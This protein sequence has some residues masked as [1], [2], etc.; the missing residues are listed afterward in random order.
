MTFTRWF[1]LAL[2]LLTC[3][4]ASAL[5]LHSSEGDVVFNHDEHKMYVQCQV[6]HHAKKEG[7][8]AC[9]PKSN[10]FN[11]AKIFHL[12]CR[13]CHKQKKAG[14]TACNQCHQPCMHLDSRLGE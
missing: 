6:C 8:H 3:D 5:R 12:L 10:P 7:C 9:H 4:T 11:R 14:P 13:S 2:L 1:P